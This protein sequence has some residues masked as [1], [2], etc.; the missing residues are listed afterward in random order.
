MT[1]LLWSLPLLFLALV[2]VVVGMTRHF[3][4]REIGDGGIGIGLVLLTL[5]GLALLVLMSWL[6]VLLLFLCVHP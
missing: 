6:A 1:I 3:Q 4:D 2:A 5:E